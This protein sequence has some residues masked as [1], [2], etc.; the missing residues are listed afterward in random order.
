MPFMAGLLSAILAL[1]NRSR[2]RGL[3]PG[4]RVRR[5]D[6]PTHGVYSGSEDGLAVCTFAGQRVKLPHEQIEIVPEGRAH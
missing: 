6:D 2:L 3:Y 4:T 1:T 5:L